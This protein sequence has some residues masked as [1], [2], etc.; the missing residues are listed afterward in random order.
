MRRSSLYL[1]LVRFDT[2][3]LQFAL[4]FAPGTAPPGIAL[5]AISASPGMR[6]QLRAARVDEPNDYFK[7]FALSAEVP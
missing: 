1:A 7:K 2:V 6:D 3:F 4:S 5:G